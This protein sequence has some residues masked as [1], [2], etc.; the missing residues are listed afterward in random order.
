MLGWWRGFGMEV[1]E[2]C[3]GTIVVAAA[4]AVE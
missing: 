2:S 1:T 4:E 3:P